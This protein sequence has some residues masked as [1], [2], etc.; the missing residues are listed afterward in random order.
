MNSIV[1]PD[2]NAPRFRRTRSSILNP[3]FEKSLKARFPQYESLTYEQIKKIIYRFN[4][5]IWE[6]VIDKRDGVEL[7]SQIGHIFIGTCPPSKKRY[8]MDMKTSLEFM[9]KIKHRNWESDQHIAKI[10]YTTYGNKYRF[11]NHELWAFNP[12]RDF[13]RTV[14]STYPVYWKRYVMI[15]PRMKI[16]HIFKSSDY[17]MTKEEEDKNLLGAYNEF[18]I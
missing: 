2:L 5:N 11:K 14:S 18:D 7:P 1:K 4:E 17:K 8:N 12:T 10:F 15:E 9:Q 13:S 6:T 16:S 3:E